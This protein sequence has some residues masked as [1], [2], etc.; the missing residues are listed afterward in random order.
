MPTYITRC[1]GRRPPFVVMNG[2][3]PRE[4]VKIRGE[5]VLDFQ[6]EWGVRERATT[7]C[8]TAQVGGA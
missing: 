2:K 7:L 6:R 4:S 1:M 5:M 8:I 3:D